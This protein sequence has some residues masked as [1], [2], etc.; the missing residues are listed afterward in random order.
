[1]SEGCGRGSN[2]KTG[3]VLLQ[4]DS[5]WAK[6]RRVGSL[7]RR[8]VLSRERSGRWPRVSENADRSQGGETILRSAC[9]G[10][11]HP[12]SHRVPSLSTAPAGLTSML[13]GTCMG[14][15][16]LSCR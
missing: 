9:Y 5:T 13:R 7:D 11:S 8:K 6:T 12:Y 10:T 4:I 3:A 1:M 14:P 2:R 16:T 15:N